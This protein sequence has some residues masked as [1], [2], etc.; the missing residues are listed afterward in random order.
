MLFCAFAEDRG[1]L[2]PLT[3]RRAFEHADPYN[4]R[5]VWD[6]FRGLFRAVDEGRP[7]L[8]IPRYNGG[9]FASDGL[10]DERL[11]VS[12][13]VCRLFAQLGEFEYRQATDLPT[14]STDDDAVKPLVDV[15]ILGHIFEQSITDLERLRSD[16]DGTPVEETVPKPKAAKTPS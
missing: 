14:D 1:L 13:D 4:P 12:D 11:G 6:N 10:L 16:I 9:L 3:L 15:E 8:Q 7:A 2:P 5:P